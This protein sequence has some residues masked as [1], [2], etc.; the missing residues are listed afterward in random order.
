MPV[1]YTSISA[2]IEEAKESLEKGDYPKA[3]FGALTAA[4]GCARL[5]FPLGTRS[6]RD[7][8]KTMDDA[9]ALG[10]FLAEQMKRIEVCRAQSDGTDLPAERLLYP[11]LVNSM[12]HGA[13]ATDQVG[14]GPTPAAPPEK[15]DPGPPEQLIVTAALLTLIV[16]AVEQAK[17]SQHVP[18]KGEQ[19]GE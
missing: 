6:R 19:P 14:F 4:A 5:R 15:R 17:E 9:E 3:L 8:S 13:E 7:P 18:D 10:T 12:K 16:N 11:W 1:S 2:S